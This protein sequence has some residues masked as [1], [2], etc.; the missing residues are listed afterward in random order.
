MK[1]LILT[2][3][4]FLAACTKVVNTPTSTAI[5][6]GVKSTS[7]A[8]KS[9][10]QENNIITVE[11][12][13][14]QGAK[15]SIQIVPFNSFTPALTEGFT[16]TSNSTVKIYNLSKIPKNDYNLIFIDIS[17]KEV[18]YPIIIK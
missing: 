18:K 7:T 4:I 17:G 14:T 16:A 9:V 15:Y 11:F 1:K 3:V 12:D 13:V 2:T 6:L 8:I 5:D 10:K